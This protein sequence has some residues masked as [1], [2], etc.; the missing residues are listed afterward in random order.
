MRL[1]LRPHVVLAL[2]LT[3]GC[4]SGT[5]GVGE[6]L[7]VAQV[8]I[9]PPGAGLVTG[10]TRQ[11]TAVPRTSTG[12]VVPNRTVAWS[13]SNP[14]VA[15]VSGSGLVT[16]VTIGEVEIRAEV[17]RV[18]GRVPVTVSARPVASVAVEPGL[19]EVPVG[20]TAEFASVLRDAQGQVLSGRAVAWSTDQPAIATVSGTGVVT[21]V[22]A[23][24][25][26]VRAVAEGQTGSA[27]VR[28]IARPAVSL[29][30]LAPPASVTAGETL[31]PVQ[32]AVR[33]A[34]G[35]TVTTATDQVTIA[36]ANAPPGAELRGTLTVAAVN[37]VATFDDLALTRAASGYT[38]RATSGTLSSAVSPSF[39]VAAGPAAGLGISTQPSPTAQSGTVFAQQPVVHIQDA[40]GNPV[41]LGG[42]PVTAQLEGA[43]AALGGTRTVTT[44]V[45]GTAIFT[46]LAISGTSGAYAIRFSAP[47]LVDALSD[48]VAVGAG[49]AARLAITTQPPPTA[50]SGGLLA[51]QPVVQLLDA[52]DNPVH[53]AG[54][55]VTA[56]IA[57]GGGTLGGTVTASTNAQGTAT[58][59]NLALTGTVGQRTLRFTT[60]VLP[61]VISIPISLVPGPAAALGFAVQPPPASSSGSALTPVPVV[62]VFDASGNAVDPDPEVVVTIDIASGAG[63]TLSGPTTVTTVAGA[64]TFNGLV[65]TGPTGTYTLRASGG[66]LP[67]VVSSGITLG[68]GGASRLGMVTQPSATVPSGEVLPVQPVVQLLDAANNPVAAAGI[69]VTASIQSGGGALGGTVTAVTAGNGQ[70]TFTNLSI[71]GLVG[72]RSLGFAA[73]GVTPVTSAPVEVATGAPAALVITGSPGA[74][75]RSGVALSPQPVLQV[76]D[77]GGNPVAGAEV[78]ATI[79]S[80][81]DG[82]TLANAV[83]TTGSDGQA[84]FAGLTITGPEGT[85]VLRFESGALG[86]VSGPITLGQPP[87]RLLLATP[88]PSA[89]QS[90]IAFT[91]PPVVQLAT[92]DNVPV[93]QAG[94]AVTAV[95]ASAPGGSPTL[96]GATAMTD[97]DG[98]ATF[99]DLAISGTTGSYTLRFESA[100]LTPVTTGTITLSA[101]APASLAILTQPPTTAENDELLSTSPV[102]RV[103]DAAGNNVPG[104]AV[105]V[106]LGLGAENGTLTGTL[107]RTTGSTGRATFSGLR[108]VGLVGTYTLAFTVEGVAPVVSREITLSAGDVA[109][110]TITTAPSTE[111]KS[112]VAF[113]TQPVV[114]VRDSGGNPRSVTVTASLVIVAAIDG[115]LN[116]T[117]SVTAQ[118]GVATFTNLNI[119]TLL[120]G[121]Y[122]VRF[123]AGGIAVD[124]NTITVS[125]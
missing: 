77:G 82:A 79:H 31:A 26:A 10:A 112:G 9:Q 12:V 72:P 11:L 34:A 88:P 92:A 104:A 60:G 18:V 8:E 74:S 53:Q 123:T 41:T 54:I 29:G 71:T 5:V 125:P 14:G 100:P 56:A 91:T 19:A 120:G 27:L 69:T 102:V 47:S 38:L 48:P 50:P 4:D 1:T 84:S 13:S 107:T 118:N 101:G 52:N 21:G 39:T 97:P 66:G 36:L 20:G 30:F 22:A 94:V 42:I 73:A 105:T 7:V 23:G 24:E 106:A 61:A 78:V 113:A 55:Q 83:A 25:T 64:A 117:K 116:G 110:L 51:P 124:S 81:P 63:G 67:A 68:A 75:G 86:T 17:D 49:A 89:A 111:A 109:Q 85:Y 87:A 33:D 37:G 3:A 57:S 95:I 16:A 32:V 6:L 40:H 90:G 99:P 108:I 115:A 76:T 44:I 15:T 2:A 122:R 114:D 121:T 35:A 45:S 103:R 43:G 28:V 96:A 119:S 70:A 93:A 46:N 80:G 65:L 59:T 98:R 62:R 58:F